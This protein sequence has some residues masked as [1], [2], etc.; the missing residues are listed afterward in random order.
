[1]DKKALNPH[2]WLT[3]SVFFAFLDARGV[4]RICEVCQA[5]ENWFVDTGS[6]DGYVPRSITFPML[7]DGVVNTADGRYLPVVRMRCLN[8]GIIRYHDLYAIELWRDGLPVPQIN[9]GPPDS[10]DVSDD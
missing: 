6:F 2:A 7:R 4:P 3:P 10:A 1:M 9:T 5:S 8:C